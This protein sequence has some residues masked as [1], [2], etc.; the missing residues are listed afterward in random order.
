MR[1][2]AMHCDVAGISDDCIRGFRVAVQ[3]AATHHLQRIATRTKVPHTSDE[4]VRDGLIGRAEGPLMQ[5]CQV[6]AEGTTGEERWA[7]T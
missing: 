1:S 2:T 7:W 4:F 3:P 6:I 5:L